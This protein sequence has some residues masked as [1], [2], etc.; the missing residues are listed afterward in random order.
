MSSYLL[1]NLEQANHL[2]LVIP[3]GVYVQTLT[4]PRP[5]DIFSDYSEGP[6]N[7][8]QMAVLC[9]ACLRYMPVISL[10]INS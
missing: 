7:P 9:L 2:S 4:N 10:S 1:L 3:R 6:L 8:F 5:A